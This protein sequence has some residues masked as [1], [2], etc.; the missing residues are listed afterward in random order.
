MHLAVAQRRVRPWRR[1]YFSRTNF[2][3]IP[4]LNI[5]YFPW[6]IPTFGLMVATALL[7]SGYVLQ[8]DLNRRAAA[9]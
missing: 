8:A 1:V 9:R 4:F 6:P 5:P 3:M 7:V 2:F